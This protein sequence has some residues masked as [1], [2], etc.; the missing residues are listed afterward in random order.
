MSIVLHSLYRI[1]LGCW[2]NLIEHGNNCPPDTVKIFSEPL[3]IEMNTI[4][5]QLSPIWPN[6][7]MTPKMYVVVALETCVHLDVVDSYS[8]VEV[9][10]RAWSPIDVSIEDLWD[11]DPFHAKLVCKV[12]SKGEDFGSYCIRVTNTQIVGPYINKHNIGLERLDH[13]DLLFQAFQSQA[14][15]AMEKYFTLLLGQVKTQEMVIDRKFGQPGYKWMAQYKYCVLRHCDGKAGDAVG[16]KMNTMRPSIEKLRRKEK[17]DKTPHLEKVME[18]FSPYGNAW[19]RRLEQREFPL[20]VQITAR[21]G[22]RK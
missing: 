19:W 16:D 7:P 4:P 3:V 22:K 12:L 10:R 6:T 15:N 17:D 2:C 9:G 1:C 14:R 11:Q 13:I 20:L 5:E 8:F 18:C 21:F